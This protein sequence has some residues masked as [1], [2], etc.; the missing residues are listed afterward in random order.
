VLFDEPEGMMDD[1]L[2]VAEESTEHQ[3]TNPQE[4]FQQTA[5]EMLGM[6]HRTPQGI[7]LRTPPPA[8]MPE[9]MYSG[10]IDNTS[11]DWVP[12]TST[13]LMTL[14]RLGVDV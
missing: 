4:D 6:M 5:L 7:S 3:Q 8:P 14:R 12:I 2:F 13:D 9:E 1:G 10:D 11:N